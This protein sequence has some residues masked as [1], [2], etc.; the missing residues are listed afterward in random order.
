MGEFFQPFTDCQIAREGNCFL[1]LG[2]LSRDEK[3]EPEFE[4]RR[5]AKK[6]K[7]KRG[8]GFS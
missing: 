6:E 5:T 1:G 4:S 8:K 3:K 7:K 2:I